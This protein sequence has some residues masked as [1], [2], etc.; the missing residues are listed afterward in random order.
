MYFCI[1]KL[2]LVPNLIYVGMTTNF[3]RRLRD[4]KAGRGSIYTIGRIIHDHG[5]LWQGNVNNK[6]HAMLIENAQARRQAQQNPGY[7]VVGGELTARYKK[8]VIRKA[9]SRKL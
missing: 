9:F 6:Y 4:H 3:R 2:Y 7:Q 8:I 5:I 1:Y